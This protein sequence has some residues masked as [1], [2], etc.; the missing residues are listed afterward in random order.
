MSW[1][2]GSAPRR[3]QTSASLSASTRSS[4][5]CPS[6]SPTGPP[7]TTNRSSTSSSMNAAC[8]SQPGCSRR[9]S[10]A[11]HEGPCVR[12]TRKYTS[13]LHVLEVERVR[14]RGRPC[15][16]PRPSSQEWRELLGRH[17]HHRADERADHVAEETVGRDLELERVAAAVPLRTQDVARE[18]LVLRLPRRKSE[19]VVPAEQQIGGVREPVL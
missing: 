3:A 5:E 15:F 7:S 10:V 12:V 9:T 13:V 18:P 14:R 17:L 11:S 16:A 19:K 8:A 1:P 2:Q 4:A 6:P